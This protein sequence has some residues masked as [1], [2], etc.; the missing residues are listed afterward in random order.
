MFYEELESIKQ[1]ITMLDFQHQV[2]HRQHHGLLQQCL[3]EQTKHKS[4]QQPFL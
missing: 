1:I 2:G 3:N 4:K